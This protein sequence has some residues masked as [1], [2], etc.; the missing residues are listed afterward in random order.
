MQV[1][2]FCA[3]PQGAW[4]TTGEARGQ[5]WA[6][7]MDCDTFGNR[8]TYQV[9]V[10]HIRER[11]QLSQLPLVATHTLCFTWVLQDSCFP[12]FLLTH[13]LA[14]QL[15]GFGSRLSRPS[16]PSRGPDLTCATLNW[17]P[18]PLFFP[19][20]N[21]SLEPRATTFQSLDW[22]LRIFKKLM[23]DSDAYQP[24][25]STVLHWSQNTHLTLTLSTLKIIQE[26]PRTLT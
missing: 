15:W 7:T 12:L 20:P 1:V 23:Y 25:G 4:K 22:V 9:Q 21:G 10:H 8:T 2:Q 6:Q 14:T 13:G 5:T 19:S 26:Y 3:S 16:L 18:W 17:F 11:D 24:V